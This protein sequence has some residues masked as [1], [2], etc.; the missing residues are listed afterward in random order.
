MDQPQATER[1][2]LLEHELQQTREREAAYRDWLSET[3]ERTQRLRKH[4]AELLETLG[5]RPPK[6]RDLMRTLTDTARISS[7][8]LSVARTSLWMFDTAGSEL[9]CKLILASDAS[10]PTLNAVLPVAQSPSYFQAIGANGVVAIENVLEDP[11]A[12]G[13]EAYLSTHGVNAL[14]DISIAIPGELMGVV[15]H[16]HVGAPRV[17]HPEEIDFATHVS[18]L[19][20][21]ALE[22][23]RRQQAE[24]K[25]LS[26]E[27]RYRYLVESLPVTVYS[28]DAHSRRVDYLSPQIKE[29]GSLDADGWLALGINGWLDAIHEDDRARVEA[30]FGPRGVDTGP[31]EIQYRVKLKNGVRY[32]RDHCRVVRNH[33]GEPIAIQGVLADITE[34]RMSEDRA[35]ELERRM[36]TLIEHVDLLAM[37]L[38]PEGKFESVNPC[39]ERVTGYSSAQLVGRDAFALLAPPTEAA[40]IR[41]RFQADL[42]R[43]MTQRRFEH[44]IITRAGERRRI[45]WTTVVLRAE[46]A[47]PQGICSLGLDITDRT[48]RETELLQ[49]TKLESLG[50]LSAG[51]AHDFNNLLTVMSAQVESLAKLHSDAKTRGAVGVFMQSLEQASQLTRS[52]L[53]YA[54][55]EPVSPMPVEVDRL[56]EELT[57]LLSTIA[58]QD[59][60]LA[61]ALHAEGVCVVIDPAHLRQLLLNLTSNAVDATRGHGKQVIVSTALE[62]V[63]RAATDEVGA[64]RAGRYLAIAVTD[65]GCGMDERTIAR[66]FEPFFT[67]KQQG[68]GTGLG[69]AMCQ[70]I[71]ARADGFIRVQS[72]V[73]RGTTCRAYLPAAETCTPPAADVSRTQSGAQ[74]MPSALVVEDEPLVRRLLLA[75]LEELA[76][77]VH[78]AGTIAEATRIAST[79]QIDLLITDGTLP[80]GSGRTLARSARAARPQLRVLLVSGAP[81]DTDEFDATLNKPF[82]RES[83]LAAVRRLLTVNTR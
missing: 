79:E 29:L 70:S 75:V 16:E 1:T 74:P 10:E 58:G 57:P 48:N 37:V 69:L 46:N 40:G 55:R 63:P 4:T 61:T 82:T 66:V 72:Q 22:V 52:L 45:V 50:Q 20:A 42:K 30:R 47:G 34:Q 11:R 73:G 71:V 33:A 38:D 18:N 76:L 13:L 68:H 51:V 36:R 39:F 15:C 80:D 49:Q 2:R 67:T 3:A 9:Q 77:N 35:A 78:S 54:R 56:I 8:A 27:A 59:I 12:A 26:A 5:K 83:L 41:A 65:D 6:Q 21:L 62:F 81:E 44:E 24:A 7:Q 32:L 53:V 14:L 64:A 31:A 28:F 43:G 25:A 23:E 17:W 19:I 60:E